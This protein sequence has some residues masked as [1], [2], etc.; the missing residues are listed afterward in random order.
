MEGKAAAGRII[1]I[2]ETSVPVHSE[3][4]SSKRPGG[5]LTIT[6][7]GVTY[8]Y[9][10][11][12][13]SALTGIDLI[14]PVGTCTALVGRSGA[15]K[16]TLVNL[17]LR[18]MDAQSGTITANGISLTDLPVERWREYVA[19]VPQRPYLFYGSISANIRL[20]RPGASDDEVVR[21]AELA[22]AAEFINRLPRGYATEIGERGTRLSAG[23]A[24]RIA[25]A[26]AFLKDAPLLVLDE[27]TSSLD[28]ESEMLIRQALERLM[29]DRTVLVIAHRRNTIANAEQIVVLENGRLVEAGDYADLLRREGRYAGLVSAGSASIQAT[30][31]RPSGSL[32]GERGV[33]SL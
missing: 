24:Q 27:P 4:E 32:Q 9:P 25:I 6:F 17:L 3:S 20:A 31:P 2:L 10:G 14:L 23:E 21:A 7:T 22:G 12:D 29:H 5:E 13:R 8:A 11:S 1:E 28:P 30:S 33:D 19:L 26:R 18:F 15:G 16:S